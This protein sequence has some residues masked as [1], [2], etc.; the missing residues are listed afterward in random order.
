MA[1]PVGVFVAAGLALIGDERGIDRHAYDVSAG[2]H[3][4]LTVTAVQ[5]EILT[6]KVEAVGVGPARAD[7]LIAG[8]ADGAAVSVLRA[9]GRYTANRHGIRVSIKHTEAALGRSPDFARPGVN[10]LI[11]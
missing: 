4:C 8:N 5:D 9:L 6:A 7:P 1:E 10:Q 3:Y 2:R 11:K